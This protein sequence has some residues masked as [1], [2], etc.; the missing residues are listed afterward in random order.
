MRASGGRAARRPAPARLPVRPAGRTAAFGASRTAPFARGTGPPD[1]RAD[2]GRWVADQLGP[3]GRHRRRVSGRAPAHRPGAGGQRLR[4]RRADGVRARTDQ[5]SRVLP[6]QAGHGRL[7]GD[8]T[9]PCGRRRVGVRPLPGP[10]ARPG[11]LGRDGGPISPRPVWTGSRS[12]IPITTPPPAPTPRHWPTGSVWSRPVRRTTTGRTR[13]PGSASTS[14]RRRTSRR[15]WPAV[16]PLWP[17]SADPCP[18]VD[19]ARSTSPPRD[20]EASVPLTTVGV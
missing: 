16:P 9:D 15:C 8:R 19:S 4:A 2:G 12:S 3:G 10:A 13:R 18:P 6:A 14:P 5:R 17:R 1:R 11:R 20:D 7:A